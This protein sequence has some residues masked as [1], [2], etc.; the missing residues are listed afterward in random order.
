MSRD[1]SR[2]D[3]VAQQLQREIS[4]IVQRELKDPRIGMI[5]VSDVE[6][7]RDLSYAKVYVTKF[8]Q[9]PDS[10]KLSMKLLADASGYVRSLLAKRI[11]LRIVPDVSFIHDTSLTEGL[12]ISELVTRAV[13]EDENKTNNKQVSDEEGNGETS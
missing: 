8:D 10:I 3:R 7:S 4:V 1:F 5:T 9:D 13:E 12:R 6:V 2:T 11:K